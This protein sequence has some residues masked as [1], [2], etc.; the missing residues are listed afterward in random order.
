MMSR[1]HREHGNKGYIE[2][3]REFFDKLITQDWDTYIT[4][5]WDR[6]RKYEVDQIL[7]RVPSPRTVLDI[8]C[9]CGYHDLL[10]AKLEEVKLVIGIDYSEKSI[11]QANRFYPHPKVQRFV[12][13]CF[14]HKKIKEILDHFGRFD[15]VTSFQVIEHLKQNQE[16]L[17]INADCIEEKGCVAV[18]TPNRDKAM[19]RLR[20]LFGKGPTFGDPLHDAEYTVEDLIQMGE[21]ANLR[22]TA[23]FAC[24]FQISLKGLTLIGTKTPF[25]ITLGRLLPKMAS[26]IGVIFRKRKDDELNR[27]FKS[28]MF[29]G[30]R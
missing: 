1:T 4:P 17:A 7:Q 12:V 25:S 6:T 8:G 5:Y 18:V 14:D 20:G 29:R 2:D 27:S 22:V 19:N 28:G 13:D 10:F 21:R 24:H 11:E 26:I 15:L 30:L 3:Q 16:F 23:R 9:G